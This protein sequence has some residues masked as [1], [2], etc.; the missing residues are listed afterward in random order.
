MSDNPRPAKRQKTEQE[1]SASEDVPPQLTLASLLLGLPSL[2]LHPP[3]HTNHE[4]SLALSYHALKKCTTMTSLDRTVEC[5]AAAGLVELGLQIGLSSSGIEGEIQK[6]I[7]KGVS[8]LS[9][10]RIML[11][12]IS[13]SSLVIDCAK[14]KLPILLT[15]LSS[16]IRFCPASIALA[17]STQILPALF[18]TFSR[19][20]QLQSRSEQPEACISSSY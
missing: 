17:L 15:C 2:L 16:L 18:S 13:I 10:C 14:S 12:N 9:L 3:T 8:D 19:I 4:R 11:T 7:T 6:A 1:S 20:W 5:R